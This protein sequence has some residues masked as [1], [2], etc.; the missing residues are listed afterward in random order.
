MLKWPKVGG[1][2]SSTGSRE[3]PYRRDD[4]AALNVVKRLYRS[5]STVGKDA[6]EVRGALED[7][8]RIV[9]VQ[10]QAMQA[11]AQQLHQIGQAQ[12]AIA[13]ATAQSAA[14]TSPT[15]F[16]S[17]RACAPS[18]APSPPMMDTVTYGSTVICSSL[19]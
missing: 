9:Q 3:E 15:R 6:A 14:R 8:Q 12:A 19:M 17:V 5:I 4:S 13:S 11:L 1:S 7:T 16:P 18:R 10:G 2:T